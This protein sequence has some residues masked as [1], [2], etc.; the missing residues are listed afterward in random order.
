MHGVLACVQGELTAVWWEGPYFH[1]KEFV[2]AEVT[3]RL[4]EQ[5]RVA[6]VEP[7]SNASV[8]RAQDALKSAASLWPN[9]TMT[10]SSHHR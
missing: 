5:L 3:P 6:A 4:I 2:A 7:G 8:C 1:P 9:A 10:A